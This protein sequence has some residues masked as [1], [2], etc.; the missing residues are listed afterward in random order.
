MQFPCSAGV[1]R[2][3]TFVTIHTQLKR[4]EAENNVDIFGFVQSMRYRRCFMVQTEVCLDVTL[5]QQTVPFSLCSTTST[6]P[7][8]ASV[9]LHP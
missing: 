1:G 2:T 9:H 3:G 8:I 5:H 6:S 7:H 4:I